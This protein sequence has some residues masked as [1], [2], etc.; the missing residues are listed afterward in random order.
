MTKELVRYEIIEHPNDYWL[1]I[2]DGEFYIPE[3]TVKVFYRVRT[4]CN[5]GDEHLS[6]EDIEILDESE[7]S[8]TPP[9]VKK[10][11]KNKNKK[12]K[13]SGKWKY[14]VVAITV[15]VLVVATLLV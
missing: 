6:Y 14:L 2:K 15:A 9:P 12:N 8:H 7:E 3:P 1:E 4:V 11:D 13:C 5:D 10:S